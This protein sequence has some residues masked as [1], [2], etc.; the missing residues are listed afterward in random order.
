LP[1]S[2]ARLAVLFAIWFAG[3]IDCL[4]SAAIPAWLAVAVDLAFPVA[5]LAVAAR[6]IVAAKNWRNL[7]V[8]APLT[9][10]I[11]ADLL[12]HLESLGFGVPIGLGWRLAI[13]SPI[14]LI[15]II[16]GRIVPAFTRNWLVRRNS[17]RLP[18]QPNRFDAAAV[19]FLAASLLLWAA[20]PDRPV[21]GAVLI[22]AAFL[23]G[24]RLAR[25]AGLLTWDEPLLFILHAGYFWLAA[26]ALLLGLSIFDIGVPMPSGIHALTA[27]AIS[28]MIVA[29]MPRVTL[30]HTGRQ[31]TAGRTT[32]FIF[33]LINLAA[34]ARVCASWHASLMSDLL[35]AAGIFWVAAFAMFTIVYGPM[36]LKPRLGR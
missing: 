23:H 27:G 11:V 5:L 9:L 29:V 33:L 22:I 28:V 32:A 4:I 25:W 6:E 34:L 31:L 14:V 24:A 1:V 17:K 15:S 3:R 36:L 13:A 20:L 2:G 26:G 21:S 30:G 8:T 18:V 19:L 10:F 7:I 16:G 12:M 35:V